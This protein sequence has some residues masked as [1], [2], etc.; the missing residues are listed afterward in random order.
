MGTFR[1][2]GLPVLIARAQAAVS[3]ALLQSAEHLVGAAQDAAPVDEGTLRASITHDGLEGG[4]PN[5]KVTIYTGGESSDYAIF[6]HEGTAPHEIVPR[7][8]KALYFNGR[9]AK[10]VSHPGTRPVKYIEGPLLRNAATYRAALALA[11][12]GQ[13]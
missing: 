6:V 3:A 1:Y 4:F 10:R 8:A 12:K 5:L 9:F 11:A 7:N 2:V 13:F